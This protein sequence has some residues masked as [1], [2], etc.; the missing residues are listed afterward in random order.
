MP[1]NDIFEGMKN[2]E[3]IAK[4]MT[5]CFF[6]SGEAVKYIRGDRRHLNGP[7]PYRAFS[8]NTKTGGAIHGLI[9][10]VRFSQRTK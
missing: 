9:Q 5:V 10:M 8:R 4:I 7:E 3:I 1:N 6:F 2:S